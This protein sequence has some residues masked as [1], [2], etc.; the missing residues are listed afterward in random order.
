VEIVTRGQRNS[1]AY[2]VPQATAA[3]KRGQPRKYGDKIVLYSLFS[4]MTEFTE[5]TMEVYGKRAKVKYLCLDLIWKPI[6][7][8]VRFVLAE[9]D[10]GRCMLMSSNLTFDPVDIITVYSLRFKI[11]PSFDDQKNDVGSFDYHFWSASLP[12]RKK[13]NNSDPNITPN[14]DAAARAA[15]SFVCLST[16]ATGILSLI[17]FNHNSQIWSLYDGWL[18]TIRNIIPSLA[19]VKSALASYFH[20]FFPEFS[21]FGV[22]RFIKPLRRISDFLFQHFA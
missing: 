20:D 2:T 6:K 13:W 22:F 19:V 17:A 14:D 3:K 16:I 8:L 9:I 7:K 1:V 5:T 10:G 21:H 4:D 12:K 15:Q 18:K 11:E